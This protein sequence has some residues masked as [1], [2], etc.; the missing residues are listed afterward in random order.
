MMRLR[1]FRIAIGFTYEKRTNTLKSV[2]LLEIQHN[3]KCQLKL[4]VGNKLVLVSQY[5]TSIANF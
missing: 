1:W 5:A 4:L 2:V 3:L